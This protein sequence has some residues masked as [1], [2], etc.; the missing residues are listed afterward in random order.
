MKGYGKAAAAALCAAAL[1]ML[2]AAAQ[3]SG[4]E[5]DGFDEAAAAGPT[6]EQPSEAAGWDDSIW[7]NWEPPTEPPA[8]AEP[9]EKQ[10]ELEQKQ[11]ELEQKQQQREE[12]FRETAQK[13]TELPEEKPAP[14][15]DAG[16]GEETPA[17]LNLPQRTEK[18]TSPVRYILI[19]ALL[20]AAA[21]IAVYLFTHPAREDDGLSAEQNDD[22]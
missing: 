8:A 14:Q 15:G 19:G 3:P 22:P 20:A 13:G 18:T 9:S 2:P 11:Q 1:L 10:Q 6:V 16:D 17:V 7:E 4:W 21:C 12:A 5:M